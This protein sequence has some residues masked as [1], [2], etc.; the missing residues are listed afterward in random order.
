MSQTWRSSV[1][2]LPRMNEGQEEEQ[3]QEQGQGI[4]SYWWLAMAS[5]VDSSLPHVV[6]CSCQH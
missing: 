4:L 1:P 6:G 2:S 3:E 5:R